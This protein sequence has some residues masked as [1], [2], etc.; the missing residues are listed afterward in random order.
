LKELEMKLL[1]EL[2]KNSRRSDRELAKAVGVS[3]PTV[4]RYLERMQKDFGI[5]F[6]ATADLG[7]AGFEIIALTFGR[8]ETERIEPKKVQELLEEHRNSIIF[9][10]TG[11]SSGKVAERMMISVHKSYSDYVR[12]RRYLQQ[13]WQGLVLISG[14]FLISLKSDKTIRPLSTHYLFEKAVREP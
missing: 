8:K 2:M 12:F 4:S 13:E 10:T 6:T 11:E 9:A 1:Y 7:K 3:Q 14:S 5:T